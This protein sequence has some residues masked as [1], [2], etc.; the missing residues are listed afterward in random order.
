MN[1]LIV[2]VNG[3]G[4]T[5]R[6]I[7]DLYNLCISKNKK[8][9]HIYTNINGLNYDMCNEL[10]N[11]PDYVRPF[12]FDQLNEHIKKEY[13][14]F[15]SQKEKK[16]KKIPLKKD[17]NDDENEK[18]EDELIIDYDLTAKNAGIYAPYLDSLII[19]D[20]CHLYFEDKTDNEKIRFL[21]YNRHWNIDTILITQSKSLIHKKYLSFIE[22]MYIALSGAKR[23][24]GSR[25]RYRQYASYQEYSSN[26]VGTTSLS[27]DPKIASLYSSGSNVMTKSITIKLL[28]PV[29]AMA[30]FTFLF[31]KFVIADKYNT[32]PKEDVKTQS[33]SSPT[34]TPETQKTPAQTQTIVKN[35]PTLDDRPLFSVTCFSKSCNFKN[36]DYSFSKDTMFKFINTFECSVLIPDN[37]DLSFTVYILRCDKKINE[38]LD[39]YKNQTSQKAVKSEKDTTHVNILGN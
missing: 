38:A 27:F 11:I 10:A 4:K 5:Y 39:L 25:F 24:W 18:K 15:I 34:P 17:N 3:S 1:I 9:K 20:E 14:F 28:F 35:D 12:E 23:L 30:L 19:I 37:S 8:Y 2:G 7:N 29:L 16:T 33:V 21:S 26:M 36:I 6:A 13:D 31:Y 32:T 22:S